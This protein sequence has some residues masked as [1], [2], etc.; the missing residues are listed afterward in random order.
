M[1]HNVAAYL[2]EV[3]DSVRRF[4]SHDFQKVTKRDVNVSTGGIVLTFAD[5]TRSST[6]TLAEYHREAD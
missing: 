4:S 6:G 2:V 5:G 1:I 3:G